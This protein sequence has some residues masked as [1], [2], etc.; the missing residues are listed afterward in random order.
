MATWIGAAYKTAGR[1]GTAVNLI[2]LHWMAG[3]LASTRTTFTDGQRQASAHYGVE[4]RQVDQYVSEADTA[5]SLGNWAA[6]LRSIS[7]EISAGPGRDATPA[8]IATV[9]ALVTDLCR[10]YGLTAAAIGKHKD[11]SATQCPGT[12]PVEAIRAAVAANLAGVQQPAI[13]PSPAPAPS[14][15][16]SAII[17]SGGIAWTVEPGDTLGGIA[18]YYGIGVDRL[19]AANSISDPDRIDV[20]QVLSI[21]GPL[22]W[23]VD[24]GDTLGAIGAH[25]G[26]SAEVIAERNGISNPDRISVDQYLEI[27][28]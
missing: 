7:V 6:N 21:P 3:T 19:A 13:A 17:R 27:L 23:V 5:W 20:G 22:G 2:V 14:A 9:I 8:T 16:V 10:R 18:G 4:D 26:I 15:S 24:P 28:A 11:Y 1:Q 25:Y 12:I